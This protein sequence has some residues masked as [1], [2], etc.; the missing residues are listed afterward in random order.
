MQKLNLDTLCNFSFK[1]GVAEISPAASISLYELIFLP[2]KAHFYVQNF[3]ILINMLRVAVEH[4]MKF[5][6]YEKKN[7]F[8]TFLIVC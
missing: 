8:F 2:L 4:F 6:D 5:Y 7:E 3:K 1:L